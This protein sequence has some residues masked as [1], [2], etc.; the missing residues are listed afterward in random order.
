MLVRS[1]GGEDAL[2]EEIA[3]HSSILAWKIQWTGA[4][5]AIQ[6]MGLQRI[7]HNRALTHSGF[8]L[9][10]EGTENTQAQ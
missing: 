4:W 1:L 9:L 8:D 6:S 5:K 2:E 7:G 3:T 10:E